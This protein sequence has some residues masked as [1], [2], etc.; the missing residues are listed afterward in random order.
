MKIYKTYLQPDSISGLDFS[1][2]GICGVCLRDSEK[3]YDWLY[4]SS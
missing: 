4:Y 3:K 1:D 2:D